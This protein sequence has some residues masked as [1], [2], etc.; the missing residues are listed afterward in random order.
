LRH[1]YSVSTD[2]PFSKTPCITNPNTKNASAAYAKF[3]NSIGFC[4]KGCGRGA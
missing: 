4:L 1:R 2:K 3:L